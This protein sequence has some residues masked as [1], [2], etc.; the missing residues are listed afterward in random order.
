MPFYFTFFTWQLDKNSQRKRKGSSMNERGPKLIL[1]T[2]YSPENLESWFQ[3]H[4]IKLH[5][6]VFKGVITVEKKKKKNP[7]EHN[8]KNLLQGANSLWGSSQL[9]ARC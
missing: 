8:P 5:A 9:K 7:H 3:I 1:K 2:W 6:C 4:F